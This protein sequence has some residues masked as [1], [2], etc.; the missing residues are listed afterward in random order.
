M[1][2]KKMRLVSVLGLIFLL[3]LFR[4]WPLQAFIAIF[5]GMLIAPPIFVFASVLK[6]GIPT[7]LMELKNVFIT[8]KEILL[9]SISKKSITFEPEF[10]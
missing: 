8:G 4:A 3:V 7:I 10:R 2:N 1:I 6:E 5:L 9:I